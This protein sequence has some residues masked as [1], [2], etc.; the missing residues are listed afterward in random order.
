MNKVKRTVLSTIQT[1]KL[2]HHKE[3]NTVVIVSSP[4]TLNQLSI[5]SNPKRP[6]TVSS[7]IVPAVPHN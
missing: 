4:E 2:C 7:R 6:S 5:R 3:K 1:Y